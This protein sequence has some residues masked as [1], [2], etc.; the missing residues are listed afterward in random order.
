[1]AVAV[2]VLASACA[3]GTSKICQR[4]ARHFVADDSMKTTETYTR[5][6]AVTFPELKAGVCDPDSEDGS[7]RC[8]V[9]ERVNA[10]ER[11][12]YAERKAE[13]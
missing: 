6:L 11:H 4:D 5:A 13:R 9:Y 2:L 7:A 12:C 1:M 8:F 10:L 3:T